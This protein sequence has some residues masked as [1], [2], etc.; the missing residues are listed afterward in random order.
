[1]LALIVLLPL[2]V[3]A[4][5]VA[6]LKG[7]DAAK[8]K[9]AAIAGSAAALALILTV[10]YGISAVPWFSVGSNSVGIVVS[11]TP[12]SY[13]LLLIVLAIGLL[14]FIYSA[15]YMDKLSEQRKYYIEM[16]V[17]E[18]SMAAFAVSGNFIL[19]FMAWE[20]MSLT[21]YLLIGFWHQREQAN[22]AARKAITIVFIGDVAFLAAIALFWSLFGTLQFSQLLPLAASSSPRLYAAVLLL[23]I[24]VFTKSAQ[25]P[26]Q[27]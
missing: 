18:A 17:F 5:Y 9:Y 4:F 21:S 15:G 13:L 7:R 2:V 22:S 25:F 26:F 3:A 16:L 10:S 1:M 11:V 24:A 12:L 23:L 14:V 19:M 6:T 27:E 8:A 20:M